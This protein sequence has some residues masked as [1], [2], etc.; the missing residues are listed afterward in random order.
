MSKRVSIIEKKEI[1]D[2]I[3]SLAR[4]EGKPTFEACQRCDV[5]KDRYYQYRKDLEKFTQDALA[6][7]AAPPAPAPQVQQAPPAQDAQDAQE[8]A[9]SKGLG[10][11]TRVS[12]PMS[13]ENYN[14]VEALAKRK[15]MP[16]SSLC[17]SLLD[18]KIRE[19]IVNG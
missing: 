3:D 15:A 19:M 7:P 17:A 2:K 9:K 12:V 8:P 11:H 6:G 14:Y 18:E 16:L 1:V 5:S 10:D 13:R 4:N